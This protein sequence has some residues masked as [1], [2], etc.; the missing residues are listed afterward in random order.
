MDRFSEQEATAVID[1]LQRAQAALYEDGDAGPVRRVLTE[2]VVWTVP[3][4]SPIAG[5][6]EGVDDVVAYM[7]AR[8]RRADGTFRMHRRALLVGG[9]Y[10]A[11][12]TDGDAVIGGQSHSW[13]TIGLYELETSRIRSCRLIP[14]DQAE[15]DAIWS[16][17]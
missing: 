17:G 12:L 13:S 6:Y 7:L 3:G 11:A 14:F 4:S 16:G 15:F 8:G 2:S 10:V 9:P 1:A 5:V